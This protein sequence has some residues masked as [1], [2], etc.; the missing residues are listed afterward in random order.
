M[1]SGYQQPDPIVS[2]IFLFDSVCLYTNLPPCG[3]YR[4]FGYSEF[5]FGLES[6]IDRI[7]AHLKLDPVALRR[8]NAIKE[9]D[10]LAYGVPMNPSG[11]I[12]AIDAV[13]KEIEW[14]KK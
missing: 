9:G 14:G 1:Q 13:A 5:M 7:A 3:A 11:L 4:G 8:K 6:H 10:T 12:Q 2:Q